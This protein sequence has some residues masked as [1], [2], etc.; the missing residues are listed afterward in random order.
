MESEY[1]KLNKQK[2]NENED[3][4]DRKHVLPKPKCHFKL[5]RLL[6]KLIKIYLGS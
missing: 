1:K 2:E 4:N 6:S 3:N 5:L